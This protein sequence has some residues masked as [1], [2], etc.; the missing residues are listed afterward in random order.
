MLIEFKKFGTTLISRESGREAFKVIERNLRELEENENLTVDF[1]GVVT[2][3]PS[4]GD[5]TLTPLYQRYGKK[6]ILKNTQN[7]S[8]KATIELLQQIKAIGFT[9]E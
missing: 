5:E 3:S 1:D 2:F 7:L 8:V 6:L 4:W 9:T